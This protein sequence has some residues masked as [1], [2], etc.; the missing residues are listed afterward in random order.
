MQKII[1]GL[2]KVPIYNGNN[3]NEKGK[4]I[5]DSQYSLTLSDL[6]QDLIEAQKTVMDTPLDFDMVL[7]F[8]AR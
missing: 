4:E 6:L 5:I 3:K 8:I 2:M 7:M 1:C